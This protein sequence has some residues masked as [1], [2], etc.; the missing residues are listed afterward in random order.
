MT[1]GGITKRIDD[2][3][4]PT[5]K[6]RKLNSKNPKYQKP[7]KEDIKVD[8]RFVQEVKGVKVYTIHS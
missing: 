2:M 5:N 3:D 4:I 1:S 6:K 7:N 8:K